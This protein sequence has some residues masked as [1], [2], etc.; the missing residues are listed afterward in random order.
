MARSC[1][2]CGKILEDHGKILQDL[3]QDLGGS[4]QDLLQNLGGPWQDLAGF[5]VRS[6]KIM[7]RSCRICT[8]IMPRSYINPA[9]SWK[10]LA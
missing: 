6:C 7:A 2:I 3:W 1:M 10:D 5:V 4:W 9:R 8:K